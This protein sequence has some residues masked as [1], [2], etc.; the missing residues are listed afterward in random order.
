MPVSFAPTDHG[1]KPAGWMCADPAMALRLRDLERRARADDIWGLRNAY[2][3]LVNAERLAAWE[4]K[5]AGLGEADLP[6]SHAYR[7]DVAAQSGSVIA[8]DRPVRLR[9]RGETHP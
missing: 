7:V 2:A 8:I 3:D 1:P 9:S 6:P 5:R 4:K